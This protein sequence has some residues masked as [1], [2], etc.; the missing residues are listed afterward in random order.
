MD[1][2]ACGGESPTDESLVIAVPTDSPFSCWQ[3][4]HIHY[5]GNFVPVT[6]VDQCEACAPHQVD[7]TKAVF[8]AL[9]PLEVGQLEG[10]HLVVYD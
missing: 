6:V 2:P 7:A 8:S 1:N 4:V 9:A 3:S 5:N 10:A